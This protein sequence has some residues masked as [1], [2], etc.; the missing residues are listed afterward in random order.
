MF[1]I[2]GFVPLNTDYGFGSGSGS[3][4]FLQWLSKS[5]KNILRFILVISSSV[6]KDNSFFRSHKTVEICVFLNLVCSLM[7]ILYRLFLQC[8]FDA[9]PDLNFHFDV[10]TDLDPDHTTSFTNIGKSEPFSASPPVLLVSVIIFMTL[11]S[12]LKFFV[13]SVVYLYFWLQWVRY[14]S[15]S[16]KTM[17]IK[18][19]QIIYCFGLLVSRGHIVWIWIR[20]SCLRILLLSFTQCGGSGTFWCGSVHLTNGSGSC[21]F[22]HWPSRRQQKTFLPLSFSA[23][24]I[25]K[26]HL[27]HFLQ[28][29]KI[30]QEVTKQ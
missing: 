21:H 3:F 27:H 9:D 25:F 26:V 15:G 30:Q 10:K 18:T 17:R 4:S 22:R 1:R 2:R 29:I 6:C 20:R 23:Y 28:K 19:W 13:K 11:D 14:V 12:I 16:G 7:G 24:Y 8:C 5:K